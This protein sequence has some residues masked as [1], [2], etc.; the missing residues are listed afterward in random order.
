MQW[1][2]AGRWGKSYIG[3]D[4]TKCKRLKRW[5]D[6]GEPGEWWWWWWGYHNS[7]VALDHS[8]FC[9]VDNESRGTG[10]K[11]D[12]RTVR[13]SRDTSQPTGI[14]QNWIYA[15]SLFTHFFFL[16]YFRI[17]SLL[18]YWD[19]NNNLRWRSNGITKTGDEFWRQLLLLRSWEMDPVFPGSD[20]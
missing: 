8:L 17:T 5:V 1:K 20:V 4:W 13:A 10:L 14:R 15:E 9:Q 6:G 11:K 18:V 2:E 19:V 3:P 16:P 12:R 7:H